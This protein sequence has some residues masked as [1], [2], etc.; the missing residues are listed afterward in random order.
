VLKRYVNFMNNPDERTAVDQFGKG[1]KYF[2]V[3]T[4]M[5]TLPGLP[6]FGHGQV[7]GFSER[8]GMEYRRSYHDEEA[9]TWM[10]A[11]HEREIAP[12]LHRRAVFAEVQ[13]F[14][15]YDFFTDEGWVN[16]DVFAYSNRCGEQRA[17]VVFHNR[18]ADTRG[19]IRASCGYAEKMPDGGKHIRQRTL[20]ESFGLSRDPAMLAAYRDAFTGLEHLQRAQELAEKG[21]HLQL[22]AYSCHV[23][24]EWRDLQDDA[25]HPWGAL[26][27]TL[28]G[29]GVSSLDDA[30][31]MLKLKPIHDAWRSVLDPELAK[32]PAEC[33]GEKN[34]PVAETTEWIEE[35]GR[36]VRVLL[37][38][39]QRYL[40]ASGSPPTGTEPAGPRESDLQA[41]GDQFAKHLRLAVRIPDLEG[42]FSKPWPDEARA[43]LP[44]RTTL[45]DGGIAI[46][47]TILGWCALEALGRLQK[48][49]APDAVAAA[50]FDRLRLR[51]PA[52]EVFAAAGLK[53]EERW[54][55][56]ARLRAS[57]AYS[58][59][60]A[61]T[62]LPPDG[63][64]GAPFSW[65][66]DPDLA[67]LVG[68]HEH[69][70][71]RYLVKEPFEKLLWW[72]TLR[73]LFAILEKPSVDPE[74]IAGLERRLRA[75]VRAV[76]DRGYRVEALFE[77]GK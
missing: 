20:G 16:E 71:V 50:L 55:T 3:C 4:M 2:G 32:I 13:D 45:L 48:S 66:R 24:L 56:A 30:L 62:D 6:M 77:L 9:D 61:G 37:Q 72:M 31:Q 43:V 65:L 74:G 19:W 36:R 59:L 47:S 26:C 28:A 76:A 22:A 64:A 29:R 27:D 12:L 38:E 67:W 69:E 58:S 68:V 60:L 23:F 25:T 49:A 33:A 21:M 7:E 14:L 1:D 11:R 63:A 10:V 39:T 57:F 8:Y 70:G 52:A 34:P 54:R 35:A 41:A 5:A 51:Q 15:L 42:Y 53:G 17:L 40:S 75:H 46:W 73:T 44:T 18:Y